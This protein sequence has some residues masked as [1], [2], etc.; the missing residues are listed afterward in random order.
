[1]Q[2]TA[3]LEGLMGVAQA[4]AR[5]L[6]PLGANRELYGQQKERLFGENA[7][8]NGPHGAAHMLKNMND[9]H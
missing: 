9:F 6:A 3:D 7:V 5:A 8:L 2:Q 4:Q 1:M